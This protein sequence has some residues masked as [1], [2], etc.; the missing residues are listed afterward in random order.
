MPAPAP[1]P[2]AGVQRFAAVHSP[3]RA[4][5]GVP[6]VRPS[7]PPP[8]RPA[9]PVQA[10]LLQTRFTLPPPVPPVRPPAMLPA[11][12]QRFAAVHSGAGVP[13]VRPNSPTP[14]RI[15]DRVQAQLA[16]RILPI[17]SPGLQVSTYQLKPS[18]A[19]VVQAFR[20]PSAVVQAMIRQNT[21][22]GEFFDDKDRP[23]WTNT[24]TLALA[25]KYKKQ[26]K[27]KITALE[28]NEKISYDFL[29]LD[30]CHILAYQDINS[31]LLNYLNKP[32]SYE[33]DFI[34]F[35]NRFTWAASGR[36]HKDNSAQKEVLEALG[37]LLYATS[38]E[39]KEPKLVI[40][41]ANQL[42][43]LLNSFPTNLR[44]GN[45]Y[46]NR[47]IGFIPDLAFKW[48]NGFFHA[49]KQVKNLLEGKIFGPILKLG[50]AYP[51]S[52]GPVRE[53]QIES[54]IRKILEEYEKTTRNPQ[55]KKLLEALTNHMSVPHSAK[56]MGGTEFSFNDPISEEDVESY[57]SI[58]MS[59]K[60]FNFSHHLADSEAVMEFFGG[61]TTQPNNQY[62][63]V[64]AFPGPRAKET[65]Q[66]FGDEL[67]NSYPRWPQGMGVNTQVNHQISVPDA[68]L[69]PSLINSGSNFQWIGSNYNS[70]S[71]FQYANNYTLS[72]MHSMANNQIASISALRAKALIDHQKQF[73]SAT[74]YEKRFRFNPRLYQED[75]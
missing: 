17:P 33:E 70:N 12:V 34:K 5:A 60:G 62:V 9:G 36:G 42:L 6:Q 25:R 67:Q 59:V 44:P 54:T 10:K 4:G 35:V 46:I 32:K 18:A 57:Y 21:T 31:R 28:I 50:V 56:D 47:F 39:P 58:P 20:A 1:M 74:L 41:Y 66:I 49:T 69:F 23:A 24:A 68:S 11:I 51:T 72:F 14:A 15:T 38:K 13:V 7:A 3:L 55:S 30:R 19:P 52:N 8:A 53:D 16:S 37:N 63:N 48:K 71:K 40:H 75:W 2:P 29:N 64:P 22:S 43:T 73:R 65:G 27:N 61:S 26:Y 45:K